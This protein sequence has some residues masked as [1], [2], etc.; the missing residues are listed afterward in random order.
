MTDMHATPGIVTAIGLMSGTSMD[1]IDAALIRTDG[2]DHVEAI[3]A[4]TVD[5][6][7]G[8]RAR[9]RGVLGGVGD[10]GGVESALTRLH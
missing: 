2:I 7:E 4:V 6:D 1:G 5:Y 9:L 8:F 10:V 3:D